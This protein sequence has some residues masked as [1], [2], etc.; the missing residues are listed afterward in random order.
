M[1]TAIVK[2]LAKKHGKP[3]E[4]VEKLWKRAKTATLSTMKSTEPHFWP[5]VVTIL[6]KMIKK[7][8]VK[9]ITDKILSGSVVLEVISTGSMGILNISPKAITCSNCKKKYIDTDV[10]PYCG[11]NNDNR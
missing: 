10:C 11:V 3:V 5:T 9:E 8:S 4:E 7:T 2:S 6:K 1:P